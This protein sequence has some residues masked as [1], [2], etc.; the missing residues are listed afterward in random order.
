MPHG[1]SDLALRVATA[2]VG[3]PIVL[4]F[5]YLGGVGFAVMTAAVAGAGTWELYGLIRKA[6]VAPASALGMGTAAALAALPIASQQSAAGW[7][8]IV[9]GVMA[10]VG[11]LQLAHQPD[12][13]R[14]LDWALTVFGVLYVGLLL[15]HL[16]LLR[17][18]DRGA[19]WVALVLVMTWAYDT[20]AYF[21]GR[22]FGR[23][24]FMSHI[25]AKKTLEGVEG[26]LA[27][28][29]LAGLAAVPALG[30]MVWQGLLLGAGTG[31]VAQ[32][33]DLVESM[34]KRAV[35]AKD[36]GRLIPGHGGLLDRIDSLLFTA[37]FAVYAARIFGYGT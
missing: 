27:L 13:Q 32:A 28:S 12:R 36:S 25:S 33:G 26:G 8:G 19:W 29:A 22:L 37:A 23:T 4:A 30:L 35:G 24:P 10:V 7:V 31:I 21:A 5:N 14:L 6:R 17:S 15:G 1:A 16:A 18:W 3:I 11:V 34:I 9:V 2:V 20:G